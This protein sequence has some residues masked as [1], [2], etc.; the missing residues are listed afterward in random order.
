MMMVAGNWKM[1]YGIKNIM[2]RMEY[3]DPTESCRSLSMPAMRAYMLMFSRY[4][5]NF[6][7]PETHIW[8]IDAINECEGVDHC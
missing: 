2:V 6:M 4:I 1:M 5:G 7:R 3:R 8:Q